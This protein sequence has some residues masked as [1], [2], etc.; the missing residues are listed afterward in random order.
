MVVTHTFKQDFYLGPHGWPILVGP[1][2]LI[3]T[4]SRDQPAPPTPSTPAPR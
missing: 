4:V 3:T 1:P 2:Y